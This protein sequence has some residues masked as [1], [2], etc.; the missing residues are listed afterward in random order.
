M[1]PFAGPGGLGVDLSGSSNFL[2]TDFTASVTPGTAQN[3]SDP[4]AGLGFS[5]YASVP[6]P[7]SLVLLACGA[8]IVG[9]AAWRR[10]SGKE[11]AT[12]A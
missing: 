5:S 10:W 4:Y 9:V 12:A 7:G 6:E 2:L 1:D 8:M 11:P 3:P